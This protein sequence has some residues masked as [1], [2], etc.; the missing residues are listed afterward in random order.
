MLFETGLLELSKKGARRSPSLEGPLYF[1]I[2]PMAEA[3]NDNRGL[4]LAQRI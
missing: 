4:S 1:R 2:H 3:P